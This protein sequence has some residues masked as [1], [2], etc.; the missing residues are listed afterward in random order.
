MVTVIEKDRVLMREGEA[1]VGEV[2]FP[3]VEG[4]RQITHTFVD[5][6]YRGQG[7]AGQLLKALVGELRKRREKAVP[8]C[9]YS[10]GYF[11]KHPEDTDVTLR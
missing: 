8:V 6:K 1:L 4:V 2:D 5:E 3:I 11:A 9:A 7:I 10:V